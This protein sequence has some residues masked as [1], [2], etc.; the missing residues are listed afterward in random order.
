MRRRA[1]PSARLVTRTR[2]VIARVR[3]RRWIALV[4]LGLV[5][6][7]TL[8]GGPPSPSDAVV[9]S[10]A[11][12]RLVW[13]QSGST[14]PRTAA[15]DASSW[16][17]AASTVTG[18]GEWR[19]LQTAEAP[20]RDELIAVGVDS[21]GVVDAMR[22]DGAT[23]SAV[24]LNP[25]STV[26]ES[27]WWGFDV[28]YESQSGDAMLVWNNGTTGTEAISYAV[29]DGSAWSS[30]ATITTPLSGE[31]QQM[32][33]ATSP[34]SDE[35]VLVASTS[36]SDD[37]ALVWDGSAWGNGITLS[38][39]TADERT[40][41]AAAYESQSGHALVAYG[42]GSTAVHH[43]T[44]DGSAWSAASSTPIASGAAGDVRWIDLTADPSSDRIALGVV[45]SSADVWLDVWDGSA[46]SAKQ[47]GS[48]SG[49]G[50]TF[51]GVRVG[52]EGVSGDALA[53]Y[54][55]S[56][57]A[58]QYR[59]WTPGG[60]WSGQAAGPDL[61]NDP[62]SL[63]LASAPGID[64]L[65][66]AAQD[67]DKDLVLAEWDGTAFGT[68]TQLESDTG[69]AS[70]QPFMFVWDVHA[71]VTGTVFEDV[72]YGGGDG[73]DLATAA[74]DA[75]GFTLPRAGVTVELYDAAGTLLG[76]TTT[77]A[78]GAYEFTGVAPGTHYVRVVESTVPSGRTGADGSEVLVQ[79]YRIDG[80]GEPAGT[81]ATKVGGEVPWQAEAPANS[82]T[83]TLTD[84]QSTAGAYTQSIVEIGV[85]ADGRDDV[86][87]GYASTVV[88]N[89]TDAGRGSLRQVIRNANL[90]GDDASLSQDG[91]AAG[92]EYAVFRMSTGDPGYASGFWTITNSATL[93]DPVTTPLAIDATTLPAYAGD[94]LVFLDA[95][96]VVDAD[97]N[98]LT[99]QGAGSVVR[100]VAIGNSPDDAIEIEATGVA[101]E[102]TW[103]GIDPAGGAAGN[104]YGIWI[105]ANDARVGGDGVGNVV[106]NTTNYGI[107]VD[108]GVSGTVIAGNRIGV[109]EA[110]VA[111]GNADGVRF[112]ADAGAATIGGAG[113]LQNEIAHNTA[114]GVVVEN[115]SSAGIRLAANSIHDNGGIGFDLKGEGHTNNDGGDGDSGPNGLQNHPVPTSA[116]ATAS[117]VAVQGSFDSAPSTTYTFDVYANGA[118]D[119]SGYGEGERW[120]GSDTHTTD[121]DGAG[122]FSVF[123]SASAT[124]SEYVT[125]TAT[126]PDGS[127]SEFSAA[128]A[129]TADGVAPVFD[130]D[131]GNRTDAEGAAVSIASGATDADGD[132]LTYSATGLPPGVSIDPDTGTISGNP[133]YLSAYGSPYSV[134]ITVTDPVGLTDT[135][136]FTWTI[137]ES[138]GLLF[139]TRDVV[140]GSGAA[141]VASWDDGTALS[142]GQ[143]GYDPEPTGTSGT[144][145]VAAVLNALGADDIAG[146][147]VV[148]TALTIGSSPSVT[149]QPGDLL[150]S[151][152]TSSTLTSTNSLS[153][154][155]E[156]VVLFRPDTPGDYS[157]GTFTMV[158][159]NPLGAELRGITLVE[160]DTV[161][162]DVTVPA[163]EFLVVTSGGS[164]NGSVKQL[165]VTATGAG[166]TS[167]SAIVLLDEMEIPNPAQMWG[168]DLLER[169]ADGLPAGTILVTLEKATTIGSN[170]L[171]VGDHDIVALDVTATTAG[172]GPAS[173]TASVHLAL[174]E[175]G[176]DDSKEIWDALAFV[177]VPNPPVFSQDLG[178][179]TDAEGDAIAIDAG[180]TDPDGGPLA[181][182]ATGL[183]PGIAIDVETGALGGTLQYSAA[184]GSPYAVELTVT[185][186]TGLTDTDTFTWTVTDTPVSLAVSKASDA[187]GSVNPGDRIGYTITVDNTS[188]TT[189]TGISVSDPLPSGTTAVA[190]STSYSV[191]ATVRDDFD[192]EASYA[193]SNGTLPWAGP[194]VEDDGGSA[195]AGPDR[196]VSSA[197]CAAAPCFRLGG[198]NVGGESVA[199]S[200]D[201]SAVT[202]ADLSFSYRRRH[203]EDAFTFHVEASGN[204]LGWATLGSISVNTSDAGQQS[205][206][207]DLTPYLA[208]DTAIRFRASNADVEDPTYI[209]VDDVAITTDATITQAGSDPAVLVSGVDLYDGETM[210]VTFAVD[211]DDPVSVGTIT[212]TATVTS[213]QAPGG[214]WASVSDDVN[215]APTFDQDLGDR[216]DAEGS[217]VSFS[218]S[219]SDPEGGLTYSATG[220]PGGVSIS[221]TTGLVS[222]TIDYDASVSSPYSVTITVTDSGGLTD[223]DSFTW[224]VSDTNRPPTVTNPGDQSDAEG[225]AVALTVSGSDPDGD[226]ITWSATGLPPGLSI[227]AGTGEIS[228]TI[229]Y[230]AAAGSPHAVTVTAT[231]DGTPTGQTSVSFSWTVANTNRAPVYDQ[232]V[233][234]QASSEGDAIT[235]EAPATDPD[236]ET[237]TYAASGLPDGLGIDSATGTISGTILYVANASSPYSVTLTVSDPGGLTDT[238]VFTWTVANTNRPPDAVDDAPST[239]EDTAVTF[240]ALANDSDPDGQTVSYVSH[241]ASTITEGT[242]S[243]D[244]A[245]GFTYTPDPD[246]NGTETFV[247]VITDGSLTD[248]ATVTITV[249]PVADAPE[250]VDDAYATPEDT[251]LTVAVPGVLAN[252][253]D[254]DGDAITAVLDT[255]PTDGTVTL[256]AD[257]SFEYVPDPGF[258]GTDSFTY[259]ADD[260]GLVSAPATVSITV[261]SGVGTELWYLGSD[262]TTAQARLPFEFDTP[263]AASLPNYDSDR[264]ADPGLTIRKGGSETTTDTTKYQE[265]SAVLTEDLVLDG[266]AQVVLYSAVA[267]FE[268]K[269][270][271]PYVWLQE[272]A[273]DG[274]GCVTFSFGELHQDPWTASG[275]FEA[276]TVT[277]GSL[278]RTIASGRMLVMRIAQKHEDTWH[279]FDTA[280]K[281]ARLEL[282]VANKAPVAVDDA[283]TTDEDVAVTV[284][285][286]DN[287]TDL[288]IDPASVRVAVTPTIAGSTAAPDGSGGVVFTPASDWNGTDTFTYEVCDTGGLC[289]TAV[290]TVTVAPVPDAP[291]V[292]NPGSQFDAEGQAVSVAMTGSDVDG[293]SL[294]WSAAG[295]P[296]GLSIDPS[297]GVVSG[298]ISYDA[299]PS[300]PYSVVV[301]ATDD[302]PSALAT[303]VTFAW[304]V[305]NTNRAPVVTNP[306]DRSDA[307][308]QTITFAVPG[309]DPDGDT[310]TWSASG[311]PPGLVIGATT[312]VVSGTISYDASPSSPY[313]VTVTA[314]DD[315]SPNL[316]DTVTFAW[317]VTN[318]NRA[319]VVDGTADRTTA[320]GAS[321]SVTA[322]GTDPDGDTITWT[323]TGLPT[324]LAIDAATG[325]ISGTVSYEAAGTHTVTVT[326]TD[327]GSPNLADSTTFTWT[328]TNTNRAPT[329]TDPGSQLDAEGDVVSLAVPGSDPDGNGLTWSAMGLPAGLSID[330]A[331]GVIG[332]SI[333]YAAAGSHAVTV[334][335]VDDGS[336]ALGDDVAFSWAVTDT[337]RA[338]TVVDPGSRVVAEGADVSLAV[339]GSDPDGDALAWSAAGLPEGL[340]IEAG[341]GVILGSP[342]YET[343][344]IHVVTVTVTDDGTPELSDATTFA[345]E[346]TDTNRAPVVGDPEPAA[347]AEDQRVEIPVDASDPD[348]DPVTWSAT[349]LPDGLA[350]EAATGVIRGTLGYAAAGT[351]DVTVTATDGG[352]PPLEGTV[353]FS[354]EVL[355]V[356]RVPSVPAPADREDVEGE[357]IEFAPGATD[358][359]GDALT[360]SATGLPPG[361]EID[362]STGR[363]TGVVEEEGVYEVTLGVDDGAASDAA[364]FSWAVTSPGRPVVQ[365]IADLVS[366]VGQSVS[367]TVQATHPAGYGLTFSAS[368]LPEGTGIERSSG[369]IAGTPEATGTYD[370]VVTVTGE[371]G[372][373][374]TV[375]F[376]WIVEPDRAPVAVPD[377]A[378]VE[379][380]VEG[381]PVVVEVDVLANDDD[382]EGG[383]VTI[384]R[385]VQPPWGEVEIVDGRLVYR[386]P[387]RFSGTVEFAYVV[388]DPVGNEAEA[389]VTVTIEPPLAEQ[390]AAPAVQWRPDEAARPSV[391]VVSLDPSVGTEMVLGSVVQSLHV[392]RVPLDL[393][394]GAVLWSLLLGGA[395]NL[396]FLARIG[397]PWFA[398]R[399][400]SG[401]RFVAIVM[402]GQGARVPAQEHPGTGA[403]VHRFLATDRAIEAT[404]RVVA[405][406]DGT[407]VEVLTP[408]GPAWVAGH[409]VTEHVDRAG[410]A[411]DPAAPKALESFVEAL[412]VRGDLQPHVSP[413]GLTVAHHGPLVH[414]P[415]EV[416]DT[417]LED[418]RDVRV[419]KGRNPAFPDFRGTFDAAVATSVL[420]AWDHPRREILVDEASVP[421][422]VIPV[423]FTNYHAMSIGADLHGR[424]RLEQRAWLVFFDYVDG[425]PKVV[426][427][428]REG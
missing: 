55:L 176:F 330:P 279:A 227:A 355:D 338:P 268:V 174:G 387:D 59:T 191:P 372:R 238:D 211:V 400:G 386:S 285:V 207:F 212:N 101:V 8:Q 198:D 239:P 40:D 343:A 206:T 199:R 411:E 39:G 391:S 226:T 247:Y 352:T 3:R 293:D 137:L 405:D 234:D 68:A 216:S 374:S 318:T 75:P 240:D 344:G 290:V 142:F 412:R 108:T 98:A 302:S 307:E 336:P 245:G 333:S 88:V 104:T 401:K 19:I 297:T 46:F 12:G 159:D 368:G 105:K 244:G 56:T 143:P 420:D 314:T 20:G 155:R 129:V 397:I 117:Q 109:T 366:I 274:T 409:H 99:L 69:E 313:T 413:M 110:D 135:D 215:D 220:F 82:G 131:L 140:S 13:A 84:V 11:T 249:T 312:G 329:L 148:E 180:A 265:W 281:P 255:G 332:G 383:E 394:G 254:E 175:V 61:G 315:G 414:Y 301:T 231:D 292:T 328:I 351:Y 360:W 267:G 392:L 217:S 367:R 418:D 257:G 133:A 164:E 181:Y 177:G 45:T 379:R 24:P 25:L 324:G 185:D 321:V 72:D 320:E 172:G 388:I 404:G 138:Q 103:I 126:A 205:A 139:S 113:G 158:L 78:A 115:G 416:L 224:T 349:G 4:L 74:A 119:P 34:I 423:E 169:A 341:T 210:I 166:T 111:A 156:D 375:G 167:A 1:A 130:Q 178:D 122:S 136:S 116:S 77:D 365:P 241:D 89:A 201:L 144:V 208:A 80:P 67:S 184:A 2:R 21:G 376:R 396:G 337:N 361:L 350:I 294:T 66:L 308:G 335:V 22:W 424:E 145:L 402:A 58:V 229:D 41:I 53:V 48:T 250:V 16:S 277:L 232:D 83:Q 124:T 228:G 213:D 271:H 378:S 17:A 410:F 204:G 221:S 118:T 419:W 415:H 390:I 37:Y 237:L 197:Y 325:E 14:T 63:Q 71:T 28:A 339:A 303:S 112:V 233:T 395:V 236:G 200:V 373:T 29:W 327:D 70:N 47:L 348:G 49:G 426:A 276:N 417:L 96:A 36:A 243:S 187:A 151:M 150:F 203:D 385:V 42:D 50:D 107:G 422:T 195:D 32:T 160:A 33:L 186:P 64:E 157:A 359:D 403:T 334:S 154:D 319:P 266:P 149:V 381:G 134:T 421:S 346:V 30:A 323:A 161:V 299:S 141:S 35:M 87:F 340:A 309:T 246:F 298:T 27:W 358:P 209:Y 65:M 86:D 183:P 389:S 287:D 165:S 326:A 278:D 284:P 193:G 258:R 152:D 264:N 407:W 54:S 283:A 26:S 57:N 5:A 223:T 15:W 370:V 38:A 316:A 188:G 428:A 91:L 393:L 85:E 192:V 291:D 230:T 6:A 106:V 52:F 289:D 310:L 406:D 94:P 356:N 288:N 214:T 162:G 286:L 398:R 272:C 23:W 371:R 123:V 179:R 10:P 146:L 120:L 100:G 296:P 202:S 97:P 306:G 369:R 114:F 128:V 256:N 262:G 253:H 31:P 380:L 95:G 311:L 7:V 194:W 259:V 153:A 317:T 322:T 93:L 163:G 73:R 399:R 51:P 427:L 295:L 218:A 282:T 225:D 362:P 173:V 251:T 121:G 189:L 190:G 273:G 263:T 102:S 219:A 382:P 425:D 354:L 18:I 125:V 252:D 353:A 90:L 196:V 305:S 168:L 171:A 269:A 275:G 260:G 347:L 182:S 235:L 62:N 9:T 377:T 147:H 357:A 222:G 79:T 280:D 345:L 127:T 76:S 81:G 43:R 248:S 408:E 342:G 300:S 261:D 384:A 270:G 92:L 60:G 44:W 170:G 331:T 132:T 364:T 304:S 363:I 242:L